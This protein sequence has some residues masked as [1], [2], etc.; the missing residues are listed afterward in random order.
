MDVTLDFLSNTRALDAQAVLDAVHQALRR[1]LVRRRQQVRD[2]VVARH[3]EQLRLPPRRVHGVLQAA[4][5]R[6]LVEFEGVRPQFLE[7]GRR[8]A[9]RREGSGW[10][11]GKEALQGL[12]QALGQLDKL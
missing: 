6:V 3:L 2:A 1:V 9:R 4:G 7:G 8:R 5:L 11:A 12:R 10:P